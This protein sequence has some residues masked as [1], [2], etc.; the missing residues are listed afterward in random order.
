MLAN[1]RTCLV[2]ITITVSM[3]TMPLF[4]GDSHPLAPAV[5]FSSLSGERVSLDQFRGSVVLLN[6]WT[7][8]CS[9]CLSEIPTLSALQDQY[10]SRGLRVIGVAFDDHPET[11]R[12][13]VEQR[14]LHYSVTMGNAEAQE[15]FGVEGFPVTFLIGRD[16]RIYSRHTG[17]TRREALQSELTQLLAADSHSSLEQFH[18]SENADPVELPTSAE[19]QSEVPG[20]DVSQLSPQQLTELKQR[21]S[22][23]ECPCGCNR[24]VLQCRTNHSSCKE[25][26]Q[27]AREALEKLRTPMI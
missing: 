8:S 25:S 5:S 27:L 13:V 7:T 4:A 16:G 21:L 14:D 15:R 12:K 23:A 22:A 19:L 1:M 10:A 17:A 20:V 24:S 3:A 18:P 2:T 6:L 26:K 11:V 9:V